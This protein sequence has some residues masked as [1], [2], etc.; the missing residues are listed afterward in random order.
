MYANVPVIGPR[1]LGSERVRR[2]PSTPEV[3]QPL[4]CRS[5]SLPARQASST[6]V[7]FQ[8]AF[9]TWKTGRR[10]PNTVS[11]E[12]ITLHRNE[13]LKQ[14]QITEEFCLLTHNAM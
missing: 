1:S 3:R 7:E 9:G 12:D 8:P 13:R 14:P 11:G 5:G 4:Q 6:A 2:G 10:Q